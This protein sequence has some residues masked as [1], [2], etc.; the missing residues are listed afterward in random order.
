MDNLTPDPNQQPQS[1]AP[2]VP[3]ASRNKLEDLPIDARIELDGYFKR[4]LPVNK[5]KTLIE[6]NWIGKTSELPANYM[7]YKSYFELH[8]NRLLQER[9]KEISDAQQNAKDFRDLSGMT[10]EIA[11]GNTPEFKD[12]YQEILDF[13]EDRLAF[14][15]EQQSQGFS[16]PQYETVMVQYAKAKKEILE[17]LEDYKTEVDEKVHQAD[18]AFIENYAYE[19]L[20]EVYNTVSEV[21]GAERYSEFKEKLKVKIVKVAE[22][23]QERHTKSFNEL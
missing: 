17:K 16:S 15:Q 13:I 3:P 22:R 2:M 5:I 21:F 8:K 11:N 12:K 18:L 19:L 4:N 1:F 14:I 10:D 7:T 9:A 20:L 6:K 23:A